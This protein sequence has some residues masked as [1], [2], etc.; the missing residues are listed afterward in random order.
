MVHPTTRAGR[1]KR[2]GARLRC[3]D[4]KGPL[5]ALPL[6]FDVTRRV[7]KRLRTV[8]H[9]CR[10]CFNKRFGEPDDLGRTSG[11]AVAAGWKARGGSG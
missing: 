5:P 6:R 4:C 9:Y 7:G 8:A 10:L 2:A 11:G 3:T 1:L